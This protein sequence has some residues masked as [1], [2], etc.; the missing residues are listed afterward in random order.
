MIRV[1]GTPIEL[2]EPEMLRMK[3]YEPILL[4]G[5]QRF[6]QVDIRIKVRGGGFSSR[7]YAI[8]QAI[9]KSLVAYYQKCEYCMQSKECGGEECVGARARAVC[10]RK[11]TGGGV[12]PTADAQNLGI[13]W[14]DAAQR[15]G[16]GEISG[17][18][19]L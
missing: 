4:L 14:S 7:V 18:R 10:G 3:A 12:T 11:R 5:T 9:S 19:A 1:N 6:A 15:L 2:L 17:L 16:R 13:S 8:R